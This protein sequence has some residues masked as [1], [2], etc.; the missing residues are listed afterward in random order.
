MSSLVLQSTKV[1]SSTKTLKVNKHQSSGIENRG[2]S[3]ELVY[4]PSQSQSQFN[5]SYFVVNINELNCKVH[6]LM[7]QFQSN[8][9]N[10]GYQREYWSISTIF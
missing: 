6:A 9:W 3:H 1:G 2:F 10:D 8:F 5:S 4:I 7:L